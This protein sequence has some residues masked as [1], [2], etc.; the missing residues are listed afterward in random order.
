MDS[1]AIL[2]YA[3]FQLTPTRTRCDLIVFCGKRSEK[4][5]SGL[6]EPFVAH[7]QYAKDQIPKGGYSITLRPPRDDASWFTKATFQRFV[8]FVNTPEILERIIRIEREI[9]QIDGSTQSSENPTVDEAG[10]SVEGTDGNLKKSTNSSKLSSEEEDPGAELRGHSRARLQHL[11]DS[12]KTL[13]LKEQAMAYARAVVAGY[14]MEDI[15]DLICFADTFGASR[16]REACID[17]KELYN[18]KHSDDQWRDELAAVQASS[19]T[20]LPYLATSGVMLTGENFHGNGFS[21]PLERTGSSDTDKSKESNSMGEQRPNMQQVPWMNQIPPYMYNFQGPMQ[22]MPAYQGYP[23]PGMP[24]Y[25]LGN[26]GWQSP[27]GPNSNHRSSRRK[28]KSFN[29]D[30]SEEDESTASGDSDVGTDSNV[31][32]EQD[33]KHSSRGKKNKKSSKTVVIRNINYI[34]SQRRNGD[35]NEHSEESTGDD[36]TV[37]LEKHA[38]KSRGNH[39]LGNSTDADVSEGGKSADPWG[40]FQNLL[41]SSEDSNPTKHHAGDPMDEQ[42]MMNDS[43]GGRV[44]HEAFDLGSEKVKRQPLASDDS[45][46]VIHREGENGSNTHIVG[47]ANG[48]ETQTTMKRTVSENENTLFARQSIGSRTTTLGGLQDFSSESATIRNR[49]E[50]DW[51]VVNSQTQEGKQSGFVNHNSFSSY[52]S[53][54][55]R[56]EAAGGAAVV[57]D[58]FIIESRSRADDQYVSHWRSDV[59]MDGE[60]DI[61]PQPEKGSPAISGSAEPDDLC[62]VLVRES[63]ESGASWTPDMDYETEISYNEADK[64]SP[65]SKMNGEAAEETAVNGKQA[66]GKKTAAK[67]PMRS[68][69]PTAKPDPYSKTKKISSASRLLTQKSKL[70]REEEERK[71]LEDALIQRQKRIA[72]R[73]AASGLSPAASKKLP[74][75]S[76]STPP[77]LDRVRSSSAARAPKS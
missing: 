25:Y 29:A 16:L 21:I 64:I 77:K 26:M 18:R 8:R 47:F 36:A 19:M 43:N 62:M 40:A 2:D 56:K 70:Q 51:F 42:F 5:A 54:M 65:S 30:N 72:E 44:S 14:E 71:R 66:N 7:L 9:L 12:R 69:V 48:E 22:Q 1:N 17:F 67:S 59:I 76:K 45:V 38:R 28:E 33:K 68:R 74:V 52:A 3:L 6:L 75:G 4:L 31:E 15:D 27:G 57:D 10:H 23:Y 53:D 35:D 24:P 34:T 41:L 49:R 61:A 46:L 73:S 60:M 13:L 63:Q 11:M 20:D 37:S 58:S 39:E 55:V 50:E 32:Q